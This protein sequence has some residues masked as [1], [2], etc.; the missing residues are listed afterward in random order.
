MPATALLRRGAVLGLLGDLS[1]LERDGLLRLVRV[2]GTRVDLE[3]AQHLPAQ[4]VL[5]QH[6]PYRL[7]DGL[8]R[9][10][11]HQVAVGDGPQSAW[12]TG[13]PVRALVSELVAG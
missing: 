10:G 1:D 13:M 3:L 4:G 9:I 2:L 11:G 6:S 8:G 12:V 5:R 7:G